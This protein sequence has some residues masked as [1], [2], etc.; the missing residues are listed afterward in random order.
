[1]AQL[2]EQRDLDALWREVGAHVERLAREHAHFQDFFEQSDEAY[3]VTDAQGTIVDLNGAATDILQRRRAALRGQPLAGF[4]ALDRRAQFRAWLARLSGGD[5]GA[6]RACRTVIE[7][8]EMRR[9]ATLSARAIDR[10]EGLTG[11]CWLLQSEL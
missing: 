2:P 8:P 11:I 5:A 7:T 1:M 9:D 6:P 4:V 10:P 3:L